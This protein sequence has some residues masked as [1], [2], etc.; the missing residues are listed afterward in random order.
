MNKFAIIVA[1]AMALATP[2]LADPAE[3]LWRTSPDDNGNSGNIQIVPCGNK[4][5]GTL[6][7]SFDPA[8]NPMQSDN[9]GKKIIW[10]MQARGDGAYGGGKVWAPDR[11]KTYSSKMQLHGDTLSIKGCI[12]FICRDGGTWT[13]VN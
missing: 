6:V 7:K 13:R 5:C 10:D 11:D 9:I 4:L 12:L 2:A 1:L 3:G 8:G